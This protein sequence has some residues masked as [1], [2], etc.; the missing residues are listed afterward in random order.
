MFGILSVTL[1]VCVGGGGHYN[2][3]NFEC[4]IRCVC[5]CVRITMFGILRVTLGVCVCVCGLQCWES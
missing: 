2:V 1:G 4:N 5:V 3:W